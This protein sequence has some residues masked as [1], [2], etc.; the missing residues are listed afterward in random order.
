MNHIPGSKRKYKVRSAAPPSRPPRTAIILVLC[1]TIILVSCTTIILAPRT[2]IILAPRTTTII[3][4]VPAAAALGKPPCVWG[5]R[6]SSRHPGDR[7]ALPPF[8]G[9]LSPHCAFNLR[10]V[11]LW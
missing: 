8:D 6:T 9:R 7:L 3:I 11:R 5:G 1:T 4:P 10:A 2:T